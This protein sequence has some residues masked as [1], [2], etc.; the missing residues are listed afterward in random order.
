[1]NA[2]YHTGAVGDLTTPSLVLRFLIYKMRPCLSGICWLQI[3]EKL[4]PALLIRN[5][6]LSVRERQILYDNTYLWNLTN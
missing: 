2:P 5:S 3:T 1:M 4:T 6:N